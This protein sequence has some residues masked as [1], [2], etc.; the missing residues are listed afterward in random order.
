MFHSYTFTAIHWWIFPI[1][2]PHQHPRPLPPLR[3]LSSL[4]WVKLAFWKVTQTENPHEWVVPLKALVAMTVCVSTNE[5]LSFKDERS[6][7]PPPLLLAHAPTSIFPTPAL[8]RQQTFTSKLLVMSTQTTPSHPSLDA[9]VTFYHV[10]S[11]FHDSFFLESSVWAVCTSEFD[12]HIIILI[13]ILI[14]LTRSHTYINI[15]M[16]ST[17]HRRPKVTW[18]FFFWSNKATQNKHTHPHTGALEPG[19]RQGRR[20]KADL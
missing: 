9:V 8:S 13:I 4:L 7:L 10:K 2:V 3:P 5:L 14:L 12:P 6:H 15:S 18:A 19:G 16:L 1:T 17:A 20:R 11:H